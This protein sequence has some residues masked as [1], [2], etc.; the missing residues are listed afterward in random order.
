MADLTKTTGQLMDWTLLDDT[1][2]TP[3]VETSELSMADDVETV[4]HI[5]VCRGD[6][7]GADADSMDATILVQSGTA[8]EEWHEFI[9]LSSA[10]L[11]TG[12]D[13]TVSTVG[14]A[15]TGLTVA[16][17]GNFT[18]GLPAFIHDG[19]IA[20]SEIIWIADIDGNDLVLF[21]AVTNAHANATPIRDVTNQFNIVMPPSVT[22]TKIEFVN[23]DADATYCLRVRWTKATDI[24]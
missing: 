19:T 4:L 14:A 11:T 1:A 5:D 10:A 12:T 24:V 8:D 2:G 18:I 9:R 22:T 6:N 21:D 7:N 17:G 13:D 23:R 16:D 3:Y 20:D 15:A